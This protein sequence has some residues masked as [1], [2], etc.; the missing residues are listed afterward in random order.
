MVYD[1][2]VDGAVRVGPIATRSNI[3]RYDGGEDG[4]EE[5]N[6]RKHRAIKHEL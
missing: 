6:E 5:E 1:P 4:G 2:W 3:Q